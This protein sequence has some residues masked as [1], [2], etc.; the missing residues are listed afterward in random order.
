MFFVKSQSGVGFSQ[1]SNSSF[2]CMLFFLSDFSPIGNFMCFLSGGSTEAESLVRSPVW[3]RDCVVQQS[4]TCSFYCTWFSAV[5]FKTFFASCQSRLQSILVGV[6]GG[7]NMVSHFHSP[8]HLSVHLLGPRGFRQRLTEIILS[9]EKLCV[10]SLPL[11]E[12][13]RENTHKK[14]KKWENEKREF[15]TWVFFPSKLSF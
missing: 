7:C 4:G 3:G 8:P 5:I 9:L 15:L 12:G 13:K 1:T 11:F 10:F 2:F 6:G 14:C